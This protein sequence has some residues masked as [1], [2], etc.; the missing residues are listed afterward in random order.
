VKRMKPRRPGAGIGAGKPARMYQQSRPSWRLLASANVILSARS[1]G[2]CLTADSSSSPVRSSS[3]LG[4]SAIAHGAYVGR[5]GVL[6]V[7]TFSVAA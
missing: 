5:A 1:G 7:H 2:R 3:A 6:K 4:L